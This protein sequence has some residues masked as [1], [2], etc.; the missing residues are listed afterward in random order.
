MN[1]ILSLK[2]LDGSWTCN[3]GK[4][5]HMVLGHFHALYS[6]SPSASGTLAL[7][8]IFTTL[9][10]D[11]SRFLI[12]VFTYEYV[13]EACVQMSPTKVVG[14]K[15]R[16]EINRKHVVKQHCVQRNLL[17]A[18]AREELGG[19]NLENCISHHRFEDF[20]EIS[21]SLVVR[22]KSF[23]SR[24]LPAEVMNENA[25]SSDS[26]PTN[27][28]DPPPSL[29]LPLPDDVA[30]QCIARVPRIYH[31]DLSRVCKSWRS[32]L[33]SPL[34]FSTRFHLNCTQQ[35]LYLNV[36]IHDSS[37][38]WFFLDLN[39]RNPQTPRSLSPV[40]PI[41]S[42]AIGSAFA[43][44]GPRIFVL[45]GSVNDIPSPN[46]WI[47]DSR[48]NNWELGPK[49]RVGRE[50]AAAGVVNGKIYVLGGCLVDSWARSVNWAEV[51]DPVIGS[52]APVPSPVEVREKWMQGS[53]IMEEKIYTMTDRGGVV[54]N[55]GEASWG[56]VST[57]LDLGWRGR[58][59][60]VDE[61]LYCYDHL[62]KIRGYD[63]KED[64]WK[65]LKGVEGDLPKF[66][67]G[68]TMA[69]A[70][71]TLCVVWEGKGTGQQK[72][73][74]CAEVEVRKDGY[75]ALWGSVVWS[76]VILVIP[77]WSS[78]VHCLAVGL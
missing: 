29:L 39:P 15:G 59:A 58:A 35:F 65:E 60:V 64:T 22:I 1:A 46:V 12:R 7:E 56:Y 17:P 70:G 24:F 41:P 55:P 61:I 5:D 42:Q 37:F 13:K 19:K 10:E 57:E 45:G 68:A 66:L 2:R 67:C 76:Q 77:S 75:G 43:V 21:A 53:A 38:K 28:S 74:S 52:W 69:N 31:S 51:F 14:P 3:P 11:D 6:S 16:V 36:R 63:A 54:F 30:L 26:S 73:I 71:G 72:E 27:D 49:M 9:L 62:G 8:R 23:N 20:L 44:L 25:S 4:I 47:F 40:P 34:L 48:L 78:I 33:R 32:I 18:A 50:F